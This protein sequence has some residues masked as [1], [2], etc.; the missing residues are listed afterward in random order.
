MSIP[1]DPDNALA[2]HS[3]GML[4]RDLGR[5]NEAIEDF[6]E[7]RSFHASYRG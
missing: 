6:D 3:R 4:K 5:H 1:L 2:Y 7:A